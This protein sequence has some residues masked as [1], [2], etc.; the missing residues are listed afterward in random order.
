VLVIVREKR[1]GGEGVDGLE[2]EKIRSEW[3]GE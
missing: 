1:G 3:V 2:K